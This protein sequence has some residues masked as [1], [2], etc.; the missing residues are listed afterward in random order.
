MRR[1]RA[2]GLH[3]ETHLRDEMEELEGISWRLRLAEQ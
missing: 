2:V 3:L 1:N